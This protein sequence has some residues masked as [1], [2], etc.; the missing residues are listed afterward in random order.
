M[1]VLSVEGGYVCRERSPTE[2][3][4]KLKGHNFKYLEF[5]LENDFV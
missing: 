4:V 2:Y 3:A 5:R 1:K